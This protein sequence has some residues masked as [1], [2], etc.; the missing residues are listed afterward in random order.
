MEI[1]LKSHELFHDVLELS[2]ILLKFLTRLGN[3]LIESE[4]LI[5]KRELDYLSRISKK[6]K[7]FW[8]SE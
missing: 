7:S 5:R 6:I 8:K 2:S 4:Q 1:H 3:V